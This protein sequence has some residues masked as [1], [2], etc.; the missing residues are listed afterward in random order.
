[1]AAVAV[2]A[3]GGAAAQT[4]GI[5]PVSSPDATTFVQVGRLLADPGT[6]A[7]ARDKTLVIRGNQVVEIRDGFDSGDG[8]DGRI[9]DLRDSF[10]LPGPRVIASGSSVSIHGGHGDANGY[11]DDV[12]HLLSSESICSGARAA[13]GAAGFRVSAPLRPE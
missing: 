5:A 2:F 13:F 7:V 1:M 8:G 6:G 12:M 10:V 3:A 9:V 11:R 4:T